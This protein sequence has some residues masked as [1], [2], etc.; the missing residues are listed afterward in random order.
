MDATDVQTIDEKFN[1]VKENEN[2]ITEKI[3][4][5]TLFNKE[6]ILRLENITKHINQEQLTINNFIKNYNNNIY[7]TLNDEHKEIQIL[8]YITRINFNIDVL[9]NHISNIAESILL[10]KLNLIPK[11]ILSENEIKSINEFIIKQNVKSSRN[12]Y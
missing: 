6:A 11:F 2:Q 9:N 4:K 8:P 10:T 3:N 7:K 5:Q 12:L 1:V